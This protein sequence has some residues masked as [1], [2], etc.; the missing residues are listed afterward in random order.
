[1]GFMFAPAAARVK[2]LPRKPAQFV[3]QA[4]RLYF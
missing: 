4:A 2:H 1:M 3:A